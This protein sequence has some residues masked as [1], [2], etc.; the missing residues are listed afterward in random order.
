[1]SRKSQAAE[2]SIKTS[3]SLKEFFSQINPKFLLLTAGSSLLLVH[4][5][6]WY[7]S[8]L[9]LKRP[10]ELMLRAWDSRW[11]ASISTHGYLGKQAFAF[12][13]LYPLIIKQLREL[14]F[15]SIGLLVAPEILGSLVS[16]AIF[17]GFVAFLFTLMSSK[18]QRLKALQTEYILPRYSL[19][20]A[21]LFLSPSSFIFHSNHTE[22]L[23]LLLSFLAFY[24]AAQKQAFSANLCAGLSA[25]T[26]N[27]GVLVAIVC[28]LWL[29]SFQPTRKKQGL[30]FVYSGLFSGA[31]F[32]LYPLFQWF[33]AGDFLLSFKAQKYWSHSDSIAKFFNTFILQNPQQHFNLGHILH[34]LWYILLVVGSYAFFKKHRFLGLYCLLSM[35]IPPMQSELI[36]VFRFSAVLFPLFF[37]FGEELERQPSW[38]QT[39]ILSTLLLLNLFIT[40]Q[41]S[42]A[43][44]AY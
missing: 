36:N 44:W 11:Y 32:A 35:L 31:L 41:Y 19:G 28:A 8:H 9:V 38:F 27:Q 30:S 7:N 43:R 1:M 26:R 12:F 15:N 25:L 40:Y 20:V 6:I 37:Y 14:I 3:S 17:L 18:P 39:S 29:A 21:L 13:P 23:F 42:I 4:F 24:F 22:S 10:W 5:F 16:L 33:Q 34:H 2:S